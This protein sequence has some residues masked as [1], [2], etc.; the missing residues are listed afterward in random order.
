[1]EQ[2]K[3]RNRMVQEQILSRGIRD[4]KVIEAM[5]K[6]ER[7]L[8]VPDDLQKFA[9]D[10][11]PLPIDMGQT[12]SQPYIVGLMT[13]LLNLKGGE[14][15]LEIGTGSGYQAAILGEI[16][17]EVHSVEI[18][19]ELVNN[20]NKLFQQLGY[21]NIYVHLGDGSLGWSDAAPYD[22]IITTAAAPAVPQPLRDQL[23]DG[24]RLVIPVAPRY[25]QSLEV[26]VKREGNFTKQFISGVAF[27]PL[28]GENGWKIN[29]F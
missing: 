25:S 12:I 14:K 10:D 1:M 20:S 24:G 22:A 29:D 15:V 2:E 18:Y 27:V 16:A 8:F 7:H 3:K 5:L 17:G 4:E 23:V 28:L 9:Y 6:V 26:W 13:E 11:R 19:E 21:E